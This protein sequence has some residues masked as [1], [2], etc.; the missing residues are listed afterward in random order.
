MAKERWFPFKELSHP[1]RFAERNPVVLEVPSGDQCSPLASGPEAAED[2]S[3]P[4]R[5][6]GWEATVDGENPF[7]TT[8]QKPW[9]E[10]SPL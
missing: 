2:L 1:I 8:V 4:L 9:N 10:D 5:H 3:G 6:D 7:R